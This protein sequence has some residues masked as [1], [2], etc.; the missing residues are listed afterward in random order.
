[1]A[2]A[3]RQHLVERGRLDRATRAG[4]C[5]S[6]RHRDAASERRRRLLA[7]AL[8]SNTRRCSIGIAAV[9][10][11]HRSAREASIVAWSQ[12]DLPLCVVGGRDLSA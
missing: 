1:M 11:Q 6:C 10:R 3:A 2:I 7:Y 9:R 5:R 4:G 12:R 8:A